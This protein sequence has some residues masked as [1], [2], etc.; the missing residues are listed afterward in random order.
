MFPFP[1]FDKLLLNYYRTDPTE[2]EAEIERL[3][4]TYPSQRHAALKAKTVLTIRAAA[5]AAL[6][7]LDEALAGLP[8]GDKGFL[9]Q[10][11]EVKQASVDI[12]RAAKS[13]SEQQRPL[14]RS[15][16]A[17]QL[18]NRILAFQGTVSGLRQPL[19]TELRAASKAWLTAAEA[20][21]KHAEAEAGGGAAVRQLFRA[22]DPVDRTQEAFVARADVLA[23]LERQVLLSGGCPGLI[24]YGR[25]RVGKTS[26]LQGLEG[27]IPSSVL[28]LKISLQNPLAGSDVAHFCGHVLQCLAKRLGWSGD[29][30]DTADLPALMKGLARADEQLLKEEKRLLL[31]L[32]EYE[33]LD[34]RLADGS[35]PDDFL[36]TVRESIQ[37]HRRIIWLLA[38]SRHVT[39]LAHPDW[40]SYL[41]S[42]RTVPVKMFT[43]PETTAL[44]TN[45]LATS[46]LFTTDDPRRPRIKPEFWG[47][48]GIEWIWS[49]A[50]GWPHLVQL[51]AEAAVDEVN[52]RAADAFNPAWRDDLSAR[53]CERGEMVLRQLLLGES[54]LPGEEDYVKGFALHPAQPAPADAALVKSLHRRELIVVGEDGLWRLRVPL[55]QNWLDRNRYVL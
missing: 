43:L 3:I 48:G 52:D 50:G 21:Q 51:L 10:T 55:M 17:T 54:L 44:L 6:E 7:N 39:E 31:A 12:A 37:T 28:P 40:A 4:E 1:M 32:D 5:A 29:Y 36:A 16:Y 8:T 22:G 20:L 2:A 34:Q 11:A 27:L 49:A 45:P 23:E 38:G 35:F 47:D 9:T 41:I 14:F 13:A 18:V 26:I 30:S 33:L 19:A 15:L 46:P 53:A 25:R 24:L 42:V